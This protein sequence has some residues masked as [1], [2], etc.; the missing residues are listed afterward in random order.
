MT[1]ITGPAS[2]R[3]WISS[4]TDDA[5]VFVVLRAFDPNGSE[6]LFQGANDPQT[7]LSQGWLRASHREVDPDRSKPWAPWHP[8]QRREPLLTNQIYPLD[9]E[10]WPTCI[11]LPA[12]YRLSVTI[13]GHDFDHGL[14]P[15]GLGETVMRGSGPF[16]HEHP[17]DRPAATFD[18][19]VTIYTGGDTPSSL[20]LPM[21]E[22]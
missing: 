21:I 19:E 3:V 22:D 6:V 1:E 5:D 10:I 14:E 9:I 11:V 16:R 20:L 8:H 12:G 15:S 7:P 2:A 18:N 17:E 13:L 4:S